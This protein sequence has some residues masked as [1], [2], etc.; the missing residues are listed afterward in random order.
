M[1]NQV[2]TFHPTLKCQGLAFHAMVYPTSMECM[3]MKRPAAKRTMS[4]TMDEKILSS[5][6]LELFSISAYSI[7]TIGTQLTVENQANTTARTPTWAVHNL[8]QAPLK[9]R[10]WPAQA[11]S[12]PRCNHRSTDRPTFKELSLLSETRS[13]FK[14]LTR[15]EV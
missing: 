15:A 7:A 10:K 11:T 14:K 12:A 2:E 1:V 13:K 3:P 4:V 6:A 9:L 8:S 5:A